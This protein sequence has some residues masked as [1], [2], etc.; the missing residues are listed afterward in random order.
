MLVDLVQEERDVCKPP[1]LPLARAIAE[2]PSLA[3]KVL[4]SQNTVEF[5]GPHALCSTHVVQ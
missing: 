4:C 1:Y 5:S 3:V 2:S